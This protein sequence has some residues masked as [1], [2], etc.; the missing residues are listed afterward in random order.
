MISQ[1]SVLK[2]VGHHAQGN[3]TAQHCKKKSLDLEPIIGLH[4]MIGSEKHPY[5]LHFISEPIIRNSPDII[6]PNTSK[7]E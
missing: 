4:Q 6:T 2:N 3:L 5:I 1:D 7:S